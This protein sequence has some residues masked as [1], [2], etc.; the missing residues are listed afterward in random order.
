MTVRLAALSL[1]LALAAWGLWQ[2]GRA[3][4][5]EQRAEVSE[6]LVDGYQQTARMRAVQDAHLAVQRADAAALDHELE[7]QE[8]ADAP[9]SDYLDAAAGRLWK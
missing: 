1:V 3:I 9:L 5:A 4:I 2:R 7:T 8:G 6:A